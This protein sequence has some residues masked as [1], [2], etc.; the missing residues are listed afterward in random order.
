VNLLKLLFISFDIY[1][2]IHKGSITMISRFNNKSY[3]TDNK[4]KL[5]DR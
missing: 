1:N 3:M 2:H 4:Q 5:Y